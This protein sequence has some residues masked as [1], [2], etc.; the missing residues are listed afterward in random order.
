MTNQ[1]LAVLAGGVQRKLPQDVS[2]LL[3][4]FC[5][6]FDHWDAVER[7]FII[8]VA[9]EDGYDNHLEFRQR[10]EFRMKQSIWV[11]W[12]PHEENGIVKP[13]PY[14][15]RKG[16]IQYPGEQEVHG[17]IRFVTDP[18]QWVDFLQSFKDAEADFC[19]T[20]IRRVRVST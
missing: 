1:E 15:K 19:E 9:I 14:E 17:D 18:F 6:H 13:H 10:T 3:N 20:G 5:D 12:P 8:G 16:V 2:I 7:T 11:Y 4:S